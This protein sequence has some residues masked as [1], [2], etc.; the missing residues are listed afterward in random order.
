M[1]FEYKT[2]ILTAKPKGGFFSK[3]LPDKCVPEIDAALNHLGRDGW[4]LVAV[5]PFTNGGSPAAI[6]QAIHYFKRL[7]P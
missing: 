3:K 5:F 4:E 1:P 7:V 6:E 2:L